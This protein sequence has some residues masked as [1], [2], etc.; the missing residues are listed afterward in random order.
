MGVVPWVIERRVERR[1]LLEAAARGWTAGAVRASFSWF[2][3]FR[4]EGLALLGPEDTTLRADEVAVSWRPAL[5]RLPAVPT[6]LRVTGVRVRLP[7]GVLVEVAETD[8]DLDRAG[9]GW[10]ASRRGGGG[11]VAVTRETA[12]DR[13]VALEGVDLSREVRVSREG[14]AL[15]L[16]GVVSARVALRA[17]A[18]R[19][20]LAILAEV[21]GARLASPADG[22]AGTAAWGSPVDA[23]LSLD[24]S[25][26]P[27]FSR[28]EV[29]C[30]RL[31]ASGIEIDGRGALEAGGGDASVDVDLDV[32]RVALAA[33]LDA[34]GLARPEVLASAGDDLGSASVQ[35]ALRGRL[36]D[37]SSLQVEER[38][39]F[40]PPRRPIPGLA[41]L[42]GPFRHVA[43]AADGSERE[44]DLSPASPD[45]VGLDD[46]PPL[47]LRALTLSEDAGFWGHRGIDLRE[48]PV[49]FATNL[50]RGETR[51][52][53]STITQQLV[54]N[55]F[56]GRERRVSRKLR[57]AA[58][59]LLLEAHLPKRRILEIYLN[60]VEWGPGTWGLRPA[61]RRYFGKE[62]GALTV[63]EAAFLVCLVPGPLKYQPS[64]ASGTPSPG[65]RRLVD[66]L[67]HKLRSVEAIS[68]E[69]LEAALGREIVVTGRFPG[70]PA[71][72]AAAEAK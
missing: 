16:P 10:R 55:L 25:V 61:A 69:E 21:R 31:R 43:R 53:A 22:A 56:L 36:R 67:L 65:F 49:A 2:R 70:P 26:W 58:L 44:I 5:A 24:A 51:F 6:R 18:P 64:F 33:V 42:A 39:D 14:R 63:E 28:V 41:A 72:A 40:H 57:E 35:F 38:L 23:V 8:W 1:I 48:I 11:A 15:L 20:D 30:G 29:S 62:P 3:P 34:S 32:P 12:G 60:V 54:K 4:L 9:G 46:V 47:F 19:V 52:G 71:P 59:T 7:A 45:F 50:A 27:S 68:E 17:A 66:G 13:H 37:P